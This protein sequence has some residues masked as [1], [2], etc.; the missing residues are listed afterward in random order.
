[1]EWSAYFDEVKLVAVD[2]PAEVSIFTNEKVGSP[3]MAAH[4]IHTVKNPR[5]PLSARDGFG[6]D[7][8]AGLA[9]MDG[10]YVQPFQSRIMQGLV[11][12][13]TMEYF[14]LAQSERNG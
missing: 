6:R 4:R 1:M 14:V 5:L 7:L 8:L 13:W 12:E 2:H 11:D 3:A 9:A 10:N